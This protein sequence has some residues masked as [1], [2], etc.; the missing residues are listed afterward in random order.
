MVVAAALVAVPLAAALAEGGFVAPLP[1]GQQGSRSAVV[2]EA[3]AEGFLV[4]PL[5][6]AA[7]VD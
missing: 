6:A 2:V 7:L 4:V 5:T 3:A 1:L